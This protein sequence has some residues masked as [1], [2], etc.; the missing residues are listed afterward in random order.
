MLCPVN[1]GRRKMTSFISSPT[2]A[3]LRKKTAEENSVDLNRPAREQGLG[4]Y[5]SDYVPASRSA[6]DV[7]FSNTRRGY[8]QRSTSGTSQFSTGSSS[9]VHPFQQTP[10]PYTP[11][12]VTSQHNSLISSEHSRNSSAVVDDDHNRFGI[13]SASTLSDYTATPTTNIPSLRIQTKTSSSSRLAQGNNSQTNLHSLHVRS[14]ELAS[15]AD[16][17]SP[18]SAIAS[19]FENGFRVRSRSEV[20][21]RAR[22]D[23]IREARRKFDEK[24]RLKEEKA[25]KEEMLAREKQSLKEAKQIEK[26]RRKSINT[27][28]SRSKRSKSDLTSQHEKG[29]GL[30][31]RNYNSA[32]VQTPPQTSY[33]RFE[34]PPRSRTVTSTKQKTHGAWTTFMIWLRTRLLRL[35]N[36]PGK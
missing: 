12:L 31:G 10:R 32:P 22:A 5:S 13:R 18:S 24:E 14:P 3:K 15:P 7:T 8:H 36:S 27:E 16:T 6:Q 34:P 20:D 2:R 30:I 28:G 1:D 33:D 29:D 23:S 9:F 26:S 25:V 11:P 21:T 17:M 4:I 19:S 35:G